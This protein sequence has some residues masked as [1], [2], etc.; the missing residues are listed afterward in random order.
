MTAGLITQLH[1]L[2]RLGTSAVPAVCDSPQRDPWE[3]RRNRAGD[4]NWI[5]KG[6]ECQRAARAVPGGLLPLLPS[7][8]SAQQGGIVLG[9]A[10][11][12]TAQKSHSCFVQSLPSRAGGAAPF[13]GAHWTLCFSC[14]A[15]GDLSHLG[16]R[17]RE[18]RLALKGPF[19]LLL[20]MLMAERTLLST[21]SSCWKFNSMLQK[22]NIPVNTSRHTGVGLEFCNLLLDNLECEFVCKS[23]HKVQ[24]VISSM[25]RWT[26]VNFYKI[27]FPQPFTVCVQN[28]K[29]PGC[30]I[31]AVNLS[32]QSQKMLDQ[33]A[34]TF[35]AFPYYKHWDAIVHGGH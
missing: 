12:S 5:A 2:P 7:T 10:A 3:Q 22:Q 15:L 21:C 11:T 28:T 23:F 24:G 1:L 18:I 27:L 14:A 33:A 8:C 29:L 30:W 35:M 19:L 20:G 25:S 4:V 31:K 17:S 9:T 13:T 6:A 26:Q 32:C 34:G 16:I